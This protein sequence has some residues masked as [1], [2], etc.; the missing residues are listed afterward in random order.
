MKKFIVVC[1]VVL[2]AIAFYRGWFS[3]SGHS[4]SDG[5]KEKVSVGVTV[6]KA[7]IKEDTAEATSKVKELGQKAK[8]E[9]HEAVSKIEGN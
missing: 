4:D 6:D 2:A 3:F 8:E 5:N 1:V 9:A 7:K